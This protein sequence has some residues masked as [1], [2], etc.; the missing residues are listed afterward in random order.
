M[1]E[2]LFPTLTESISAAQ[3]MAMA[4]DGLAFPGILYY[5]GGR[6]IVTATLS[7]H[8]L[9]S[10]FPIVKATA[11]KDLHKVDPQTA[12]NRP[13]VEDHVKTIKEYLVTQE[14]YLL[15]PILLNAVVPLEIFV[16]TTSQN[17]PFTPCYF[18]LPPNY[19]LH[20]TDGGHR[21]Q[22]LKRA[23]DED[24]TDKFGRDAVAVSII[25]ESD[26]VKTHQDFYDAAQVRPIPPA[27]LVEFD[28]REPINGLTR[29]LVR[30]LPLFMDR[31]LRIGKSVAP[32]SPMMFTNNNIRRFAITM[33]TGEEG[34][35]E[36]AAFALIRREMWRKRL[37]GFLQVFARENPQ[38]R[39]VSDRPKDT[40]ESTDMQGFREKFLHFS[41]GGLMVIGGV[42]HAI[43]A[44]C[45]VN[46]EELSASQ[47]DLVTK[48]ARDVDWSREN[49][50][51]Q[52]SVVR[53][54]AKGKMTITAARGQLA[55]AIADVK[56][57]IGITL[58][59]GDHR[60]LRKSH[61]VSLQTV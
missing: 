53:E 11:S 12:R 7:C 54:N 4:K 31:T 25:E 18:V 10:M 2:H 24:T 52:R 3:E 45:T 1:T 59:D 21:I 9:S 8:R 5:Q 6:R 46:Q 42:G 40:G 48:L 33:V 60:A 57:I 30:E 23:I 22:A 49:P 17:A 26:L 13:I 35:E 44:D 41:S 56:R 32:K 28:A 20:I 29:D 14:Q 51:W 61:D 36:Q 38:W 43:L 55:T 27:L 19:Q 50:I 34:K 47:E 58:D 15:P 37:V 39:Y 16:Y